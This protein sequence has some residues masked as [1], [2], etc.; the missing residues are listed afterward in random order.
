[1]QASTQTNVASPLARR[2]PTGI[3]LMDYGVPDRVEDVEAYLRVHGHGGDPH[4]RDVAYLRHRYKCIWGGS[5]PCNFSREIERAL[6][7]ELAQ[8]YGDRYRL[9]LGARY[10]QPFIADTMAQ[11]QRAGLSRVLC[12]PI[13]PHASWMETRAYAR[14]VFK[15]N[16]QLDPPLVVDFIASW[17]ALPEYIATFARNVRAALA[18]FPAEEQNQV[19]GIFTA[20][21]LPQP[22]HKHSDPYE[23]QLLQTSEEV[24]GQARL[25]R[26]RFAFLNTK[27]KGVWLEPDIVDSLHTLHVHGVRHVLFVPIGSPYDE[28]EVLYEVDVVA[29]DVARALGMT[30]RRA[31]LPNADPDFISGL[32][33]LIHAHASSFDGPNTH[34]NAIALS[35]LNDQ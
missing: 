14:A 8:R 3:L 28:P 9:A 20:H 24:V 18:E 25:R 10:W 31:A 33:R 7:I 21:S 11:F 13:F 19:V 1:M 35:M 29:T 4:P 15:A 32:A 12:V 23:E 27:E 16:E 26:W 17:H 22:A 5:P 34:A 6:A 30:A 2:G